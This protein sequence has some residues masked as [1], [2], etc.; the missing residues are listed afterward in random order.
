MQG[1]ISEPQTA[2]VLGLVAAATDEDGVIPLSEH[3]LLHL[4][5]G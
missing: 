4:R 3:V 1:R 5:Y 2:E